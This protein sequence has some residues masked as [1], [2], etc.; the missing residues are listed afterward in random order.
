MP[1]VTHTRDWAAQVLVALVWL[2]L[3]IAGCM[4]V[5]RK[6]PPPDETYALT[7]GEVTR[8]DYRL[9]AGDKLGIKFPYQSRENQE[10]PIRP[11]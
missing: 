2:V 3:G 8:A 10:L 1:S 7:K 9:Q 5:G 6:L 11:D 4:E